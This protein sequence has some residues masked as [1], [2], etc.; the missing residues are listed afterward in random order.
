LSVPPPPPGAH[1][2]PAPPPPDV[3]PVPPP[4]PDAAPVVA[5][6]P[7]AAIISPPPL[8]NTIACGNSRCVVGQQA[9]CA[10][11]SASSCIPLNGQCLAGAVRRCDGPED[12]DQGRVCCVQPAAMGVYRSA[13]SR[14]QECAQQGG[15]VLCQTAADCPGA[16]RTCAP[17]N[18]PRVMINVC[19]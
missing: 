11:N 1:A 14:A 17:A 2:A 9:C 10:T 4:P 5:P 8:L 15:A 12:C 18:L 13:C 3:P 16:S 7:D 19:R 6:P